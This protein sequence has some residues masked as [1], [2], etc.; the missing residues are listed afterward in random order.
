MPKVTKLASHR[1][2]LQTR[3]NMPNGINFSP[4]LFH[5][6]FSPL[7]LMATPNLEL[8]VALLFSHT[9]T[10]PS[11]KPIGSTFRVCPKLEQFL[12]ASTATTRVSHLHYLNDL[13]SLPPLLPPM[14]ILNVSPITQRPQWLATSFTANKR[15][16]PYN[17]GQ[18]GIRHILDLISS[19]SP[20]AHSVPET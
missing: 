2:M 7:Q 12:T 15:R 6:H 5:P 19:S 3:R 20:L 16:S 11:G 17:S 13:F 4:D 10:H 14:S 1:A 18:F 9:P 8:S